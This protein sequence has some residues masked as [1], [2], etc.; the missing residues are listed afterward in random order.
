[1]AKP[2]VLFLCSRNVARSQM[3]E[4]FLRQYAEEQ[5]EVHS[6]GLNAD[7]DRLHPLSVQVMEEAGVKLDGQQPKPLFGYLGRLT[8]Q[9]VIFVCHR[10]EEQCPV[11]WPI[12]LKHLYWP[13]EDPAA[14]SG[15][16]ATRLIRFR[17]VRDA[18][19]ER[20]TDWLASPDSPLH[21]PA[22]LYRPLG[23]IPE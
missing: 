2:V 13:I 11:L 3:A 12:A 14:E 9:Y 1:M 19:A 15:D 16:E 23:Q 17:E 7:S 5:L 18:I 10:T 8:P 22:W 4:A 20:I 21:R 6:A